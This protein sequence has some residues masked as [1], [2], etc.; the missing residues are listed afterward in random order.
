MFRRHGSP[1]GKCAKFVNHNP[2]VVRQVVNFVHMRAPSSGFSCSPPV[3]ESGA[4]SV[5]RGARG[6]TPIVFQY[7][8]GQWPPAER[9]VHYLGGPDDGFISST[10][11][12][13][14]SRGSAFG[15]RYG[16]ARR[17]SCARNTIFHVVGRWDVLAC[18]PRLDI[19]R[20]EF[21]GMPKRRRRRDGRALR[22]S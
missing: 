22:Y 16:G 9:R 15:R 8:S 3:R 17:D 13:R 6:A 12:K 20:W 7:V 18:E 2:I 21:D 11:R 10:M 1:E 19:D 5:W 4:K 14:V